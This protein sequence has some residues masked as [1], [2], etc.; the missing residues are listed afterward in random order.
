MFINNKADNIVKKRTPL[1]LACA[2]GLFSIVEYLLSKGANPNG[3]S[4][5][6]I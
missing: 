2:L 4:E 6:D 1:Q 3:S 5:E